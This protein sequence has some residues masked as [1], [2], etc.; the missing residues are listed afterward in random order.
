MAVRVLAETKVI[1][2]GYGRESVRKELQRGW[3][4]KGSLIV[5]Q[6]SKFEVNVESCKGKDDMA[7]RS[8][9]DNQLVELNAQELGDVQICARLYVCCLS[10][11]LCRCGVILC[12]CAR[13]LLPAFCLVAQ[14]RLSQFIFA[15]CCQL[16]FRMCESVFICQCAFLYLFICT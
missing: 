4:Q 1:P 8:Q 12:V 14:Y 7:S 9:I 11:E 5:I 6:K 10:V 16:C 15:P 13:A 2:K 3:C